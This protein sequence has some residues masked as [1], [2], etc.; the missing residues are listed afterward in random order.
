MVHGLHSTRL[1]RLR[2]RAFGKSVRRVTNDFLV[3]RVLWE[4]MTGQSSKS[5]NFRAGVTHSGIPQFTLPLPSKGEGIAPMIELR[6]C[7]TSMSSIRLGA[8]GIRYLPSITIK[9]TG[10]Q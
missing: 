4:G 5:F 1:E 6:D 2:D 7:M 3:P 8:H 10:Q 9:L